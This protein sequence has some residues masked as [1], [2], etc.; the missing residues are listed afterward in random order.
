MKDLSSQE[1]KETEFH[2][3][4]AAN[5]SVDDVL[6]E[7]AFLSPAAPENRQ[8]LDWMG[9][10]KGKKVLELGAGL[11]EASVFLAL[12]GADV[13]ATDIS[14]KMLEFAEKLAQKKGTKIKTKVASAHDLSNIP[15]ESFDCIYAG[16]LLHHVDIRKTI[17]EAK[18]KLKPGGVA[19]F[20]DPLQYNPAI[21]V[22]RKIATK[23]RTEDE[24]PLRVSDIKFIESQFSRVET[25][26]FWLT[27]LS[28]FFKYYFINR[29]DPNK[30]RYW[31]KIITDKNNFGWLEKA[32]A[33]DRFMLKVL[34]PLKYLS[35]NIAIKAT[36]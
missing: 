22:Y 3:D 13:L 11:G 5:T 1:V 17:I 20:W 12:N 27:G 23:V 33:I 16:N 30:V 26:Y 28:V 4:W 18:K 35:W 24:H 31:K 32:H 10:L 7:E 9:D 14:P 25:R 2:D 19:Y 34:P 36:K 8:I 15:D 21:N 29:Y 6:V